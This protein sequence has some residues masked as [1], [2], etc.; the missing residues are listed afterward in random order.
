VR[1]A[2]ADRAAPGLRRGSSLAELLLALSLGGLIL[3]AVAVTL[4]AQGQAVRV[5][6]ERVELAAALRIAEVVIQGELRL[7]APRSDLLAVASDSVGLRAA[8]GSAIV[9]GVA[10]GAVLVRY[11]GLRQPDPE[12]D[13]VVVAGDTTALALASSTVRPGMCDPLPG[14]TVYRWALAAAPSPG[15]FLL[16]FETGS[17]HLSGGGLRY[18]RGAGGRQPLT[19]EL[20]DSR[21][22][23][24]TLVGGAVADAPAANEALVVRLLPAEAR[25][26]AG[27]ARPDRA[28]IR[29]RVAFLNEPL[30]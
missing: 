14:E 11:R 15:T 26:P 17:Y 24:F 30:P 20:L 8:R 10:D 28:G 3:A 12:K 27:R 6:R 25:L 2:D 16:L 22:S 7:A 9:C 23:S 19:P 1:R 5:Q 13:S 4:Q 21:G 29:L 18:R